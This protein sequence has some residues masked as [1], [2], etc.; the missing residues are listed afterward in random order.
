VKRSDICER[1]KIGA[2]RKIA[3]SQKNQKKKSR[4]FSRVS[5][6]AARTCVSAHH[7]GAREEGSE[8]PEPGDVQGAQEHEARGARR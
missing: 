2:R 1:S 7:V 5:T 3:K 4:A 8:V 6:A